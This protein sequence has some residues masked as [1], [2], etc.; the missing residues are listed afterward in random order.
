M[1][2]GNNSGFTAYIS[3]PLVVASLV[4]GLFTISIISMFGR[5]RMQRAGTT[6]GGS[7]Y[8]MLIYARPPG[9]DNQLLLVTGDRHRRCQD[10]L[11]PGE[12][13]K[14]WDINIHA[15]S[16]L[17]ESQQYQQQ[18]LMCWDEIMPISVTVSEERHADVQPC[19]PPT[20]RRPTGCQPLR[21]LCHRRRREA[22]IGAEPSEQ[23]NA[24]GEK[25]KV[26]P[27]HKDV[28]VVVTIALPYRPRQLSPDSFLFKM[29]PS[30]ETC[31]DIDYSIGLYT[32]S[33]YGE[34]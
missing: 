20:P 26:T 6:S 21:W 28:Q 1:P 5:R 2:R 27:L 29:N 10:G 14:M 24:V 34:G 25:A 30:R 11:T 3:L 8:P 32:C 17:M 18:R 12:R 9:G 19:S 33:W 22:S 7:Q 23:Q 15:K 13:P 16:P 31:T 4:A